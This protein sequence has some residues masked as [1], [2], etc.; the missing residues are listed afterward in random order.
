MSTRGGVL[1]SRPP[2]LRIHTL[3]PIPGPNPPASPHNPRF[4]KLLENYPRF[5]PE[6]LDYLSNYAAEIYVTAAS[7]I[8]WD[9]CPECQEKRRWMLVVVYVIKLFEIDDASIRVIL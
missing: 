3:F 5:P 9:L 2:R 4:R 8:T 7:Q 6:A 1:G